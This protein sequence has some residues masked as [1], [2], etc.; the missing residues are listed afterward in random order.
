[1]GPETVPEKDPT[2]LKSLIKGD[3]SF[4]QGLGFILMELTII[5]LTSQ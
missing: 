2:D 1:M 4:M 5:I 3:T